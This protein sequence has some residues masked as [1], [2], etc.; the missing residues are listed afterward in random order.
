MILETPIGR[1]KIKYFYFKILLKKSK[2]KWKRRLKYEDPKRHFQLWKARV[3]P[4][5]V[6]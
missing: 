1:T 2:Q 5:P 3:Q 6:L 4:Y